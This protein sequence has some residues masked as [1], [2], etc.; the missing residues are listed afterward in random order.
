[1]RN[2]E[3]GARKGTSGGRYEAVGVP[4]G[5]A[6]NLESHLSTWTV[7]FSRVI[8]LFDMSGGQSK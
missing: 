2:G 1:V 8:W 4:E 5:P 7:R 6:A 3:R